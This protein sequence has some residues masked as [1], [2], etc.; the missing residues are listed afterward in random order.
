MNREA[1]YVIV[2]IDACERAFLYTHN[3]FRRSTRY[4]ILLLLSNNVDFLPRHV[5]I[6]KREKDAYETTRKSKSMRRTGIFTDH[7]LLKEFSK[8][9][10]INIGILLEISRE[11]RSLERPQHAEVTQARGDN[12]INS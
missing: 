11:R 12:S 2:C 10:D 5:T 3:D 8:I 6:T 9:S 1:R 4:D 7:S